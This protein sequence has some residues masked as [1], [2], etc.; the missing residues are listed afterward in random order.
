MGALSIEMQTVARYR[1]KADVSDTHITAD[2]GVRPI[3]LPDPR[4]DTTRRALA[5]RLEMTAWRAAQIRKG[6]S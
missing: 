5:L 6:L 4:T 1:T 3:H 2:R